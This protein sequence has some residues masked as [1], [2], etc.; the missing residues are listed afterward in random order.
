LSE[1]RAAASGLLGTLHETAEQYGAKGLSASVEASESLPPLLAAVEVACYRIVQ[2]ALT[3]VARHAE[4]RTCTVT[5]AID[6][7]ID[8]ASA[9]SLEVRDD[10]IGIADPQANSSVRAG[11]GLTS[12]RERTSELGGSLIVESLPEGGTRVRAR[13]PLPKE[14]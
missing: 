7:S 11:V 9:L 4:A 10:G 2:G 14:E 1:V 5:L 8:E 12:M 13:L 6:E 3:N